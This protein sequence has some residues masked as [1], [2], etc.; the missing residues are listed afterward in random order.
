MQRNSV[1][2]PEPDGPITATTPPRGT[3]SEMPFKTSTRPK[4]FQ[5]SAISIIAPEPRSNR[6]STRG[7][8]VV[9]CIPPALLNSASRRK[10]GPTHRATERLT[11]G[12]RLSPGRRWFRHMDG[13]Y[14]VVLGDCA[15]IAG[16]VL[17]FL[18]EAG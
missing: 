1:D 8:S 6:A 17:G 9:P 10:P 2:L 5:R 16:G 7:R 15:F 4:D 3:S 14:A 18:V 13:L 11:S 12:S